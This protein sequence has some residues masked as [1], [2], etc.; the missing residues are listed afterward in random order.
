[1]SKV[2]NSL[3]TCEIT[4]AMTVTINKITSIYFYKKYRSMSSLIVTD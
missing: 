2:L 4:P 3:V 1:M